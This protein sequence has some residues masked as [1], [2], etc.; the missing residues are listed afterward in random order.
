METL[1]LGMSGGVE[2]T[3][4]ERIRNMTAHEIART[5]IDYDITDDFCKS[6]CEWSKSMETEQDERECLKCCVRWLES[7]V[8][9][10]AV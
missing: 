4:I 7:E 5:I 1:L 10:D 2:M 6:N 8:E 3:R 9:H